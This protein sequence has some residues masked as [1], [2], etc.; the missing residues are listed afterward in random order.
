VHCADADTPGEA[1]QRRQ[2]AAIDTKGRIRGFV[3]RLRE[4]C[5][6]IPH[7]Y[8]CAALGQRADIRAGRLDSVLDPFVAPERAVYALYA[9]GRSVSARSRELVELRIERFAEDAV[10]KI[11][12]RPRS[13]GARR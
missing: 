2:L 11:P 8:A 10:A 5:P 7:R 4:P 12:V 9:A 1:E 13:A 3:T 6:V